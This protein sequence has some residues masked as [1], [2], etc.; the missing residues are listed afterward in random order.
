MKLLLVALF[1][2]LVYAVWHLVPV[3][4]RALGCIVCL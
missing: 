2:L 4:D 1:V 3:I